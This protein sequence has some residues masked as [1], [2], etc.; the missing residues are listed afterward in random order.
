M[1]NARHRVDPPPAGPGPGWARGGGRAG[2]AHQG[3][4]RRA[5]APSRTRA[6]IVTARVTASHRDGPQ[7]CSLANSCHGGNRDFK[8]KFSGSRRLRLYDPVRVRASKS[9]GRGAPVTVP[10]TGSVTP[11]PGLRLPVLLWHSG[12]GYTPAELRHTEAESPSPMSQQVGVP[13]DHGG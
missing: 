6:G 3:P 11:A 12:S 4:G 1:F 10:V 2:S 9:V 7:R 8:L 13:R 5:S